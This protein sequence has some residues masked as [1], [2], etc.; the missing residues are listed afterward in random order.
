MPSISVLIEGV[1]FNRNLD[2]KTVPIEINKLALLKNKKNIRDIRSRK[3]H[4][5]KTLNLEEGK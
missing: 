4:L 5:K 3:F 1:P 2:T